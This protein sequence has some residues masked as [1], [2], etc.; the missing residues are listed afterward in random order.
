M[1]IVALL[2]YSSNSLLIA[3]DSVPLRGSGF[4]DSTLVLV[5]IKNIKIANIKLVERKY[6]LKELNIKDSILNLKNDYIKIQESEIN[7][8][9]TYINN[10][11]SLN[12]NLNTK[13][14][15]YKRNFTICGS[16]TVSV[17]SLAVIYLL[18]K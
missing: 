7:N 6:I 9:K 4:E 3:N 1:M 13:V 12:S 5:P 8:Y 17:V 11:E 18:L 15:N 2:S 16:I 14:N 10:I